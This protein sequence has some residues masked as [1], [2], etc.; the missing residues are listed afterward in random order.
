MLATIQSRAFC[1]LVVYKT[2]IL[3]AVLYECEIWY[4]ILSEDYLVDLGYLRP[5]GVEGGGMK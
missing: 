2:V 5:G 4:L 1:L 3:P